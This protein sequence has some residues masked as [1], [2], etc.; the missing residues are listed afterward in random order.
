[1]TDPAIVQPGDVIAAALTTGGDTAASCPIG[2]VTAVDTHG[3]RLDLF[4][5]VTDAFSAGPRTILWPEIVSIRHA[6]DTGDGWNLE[7]LAAF[8][9]AWCKRDKTEEAAR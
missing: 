7:P 9:D 3:I 5:F 1:M 6:V 4:S 8:Q 2:F